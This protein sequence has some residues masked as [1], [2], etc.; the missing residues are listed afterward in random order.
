ML[1][2]P[3]GGVGRGD[4]CDCACVSVLL[5]LLRDEI[6]VLHVLGDDFLEESLI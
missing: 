2:R 4:C 3:V 1:A 5:L 6:K